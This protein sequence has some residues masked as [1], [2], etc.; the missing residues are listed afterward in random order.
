MIFDYSKQGIIACT[1][2]PLH[3]QCLD[4]DFGN[5]RQ[6]ARKV[7]AGRRKDGERKPTQLR[8][9]QTDLGRVRLIRVLWMIE[10]TRNPNVEEWKRNMKHGSENQVTATGTVCH[11]IL[12]CE[13]VMFASSLAHT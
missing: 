10:T 7:I 13:F 9:A 8:G 2:I 3:F 11:E 1:T 5:G 4:E 6:K 12:T